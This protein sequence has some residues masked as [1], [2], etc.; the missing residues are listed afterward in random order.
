MILHFTDVLFLGSLWEET[1]VYVH[2]LQY[3][4]T[5]FYALL[6]LSRQTNFYKNQDKIFLIAPGFC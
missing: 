1:E 5:L 4:L 3:P 2:L 6:L